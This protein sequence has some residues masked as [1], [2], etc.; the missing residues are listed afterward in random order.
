MKTLVKIFAVVTIMFSLGFGAKAQ[1]PATTSGCY[2]ITMPKQPLSED[3]KQL[4][5]EMRQEE[6]LAHDVYF[7]L[8]NKW[9]LPVFNNI[10]KAESVH[11]QRLK[12]L[13]AKYDIQDPVNDTEIGK[14]ADQKYTDLYNQLVEKGSK[15]LEDA[16]IVG[17][18][19]EDLDI[20]DLNK[21]LEK[22]DN[23]DI[24]LVFNNIK[25]ASYNHMR[26]FT[27]QLYRLY[28][29]KYEPQYISQEEFQQIISK[30]TPKRK[31]PRAVNK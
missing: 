23:D 11:T 6:K 12:E 18:T 30:Q 7:T 29:Y 24:K 5:L 21:A 17:A 4:L 26:A 1:K 9:N 10:A 8:Y 27:R 22:V 31:P 15:S 25:H 13:L 19:I 3:E 20:Y 28:D 2:A 14:F 16:L